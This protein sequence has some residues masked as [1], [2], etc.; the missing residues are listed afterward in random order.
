MTSHKINNRQIRVFISSTFK[1]MHSERDYLINH[2]FPQIRLYCQR[3]NIIFTEIDL[4]WG[5]TESQAENGQVIKLCLD[6]IDR[7]HPFFIGLVGDRYGY[8][9]S[10]EEVE[11]N[12][13]L[14]EQHDWIFD[15]IDQQQSITEIEIQYGVLRSNDPI[16]GRFFLRE[17]AKNVGNDIRTSECNKLEHLKDAIRHQNK[18]PYSIYTTI[19]SLGEMV[20]DALV[21]VIDTLYPDPVLSVYDQQ[22]LKQESRRT[23][24]LEHYISVDEDLDRLESFAKH[25][26]DQRMILIGESGCGKTSLLCDWE[27]KS[28]IPIISYYIGASSITETPAQILKYLIHAISHRFGIKYYDTYRTSFEVDEQ[29]NLTNEFLSICQKTTEPWILIIDGIDQLS[30]EEDLSMSWIPN[31]PSH[32]KTVYSARINSIACKYAQQRNITFYEISNL[33]VYKRAR[34]AEKYYATYGKTLPSD[35]LSQLATTCS[36]KTPYTYI[37]ILNEIRKYGSHET[38]GEYIKRY[39]DEENEEI[40]YTFI[41]QNLASFENKQEEVAFHTICAYLSIS[42]FGLTERE[43]MDIC[44][45]TPMI[46]AAIHSRLYFHI[47]HCDGLI[48]FKNSTFAEVIKR[49][50][51]YDNTYITTCRE[52]IIKYFIRIKNSPFYISQREHEEFAWQLLQTGNYKKLNS[53]A[54]QLN[55]F[56]TWLKRDTLTYSV[57]SLFWDALEDHGYPISGLFCEEDTAV[58]TEQLIMLGNVCHF[59]FKTGRINDFNHLCD[60]LGKLYKNLMDKDIDAAIIEYVQLLQLRYNHV[61]SLGD[62]D[63]GERYMLEVLDLLLRRNH[64]VEEPYNQMIF[65]YYIVSTYNNLGNCFAAINLYD[66]AIYYYEKALNLTIEHDVNHRIE[67]SLIIAKSNLAFTHFTQGYKDRSWKEILEVYN[68]AKNISNLSTV[69]SIALKMGKM[70]K[71]GNTAISYIRQAIDIYKSMPNKKKVLATAYIQM[72]ER[73]FYIKDF[74]NTERYYERAIDLLKSQEDNKNLY[75]KTLF[76]IANFYMIT[77]QSNKVD[78]YVKKAIDKL[79][80]IFLPTAYESWILANLLRIYA[81]AKLMQPDMNSSLLFFRQSLAAFNALQNQLDQPNPSITTYITDIEGQINRL[82]LTINS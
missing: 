22:V 38:L 72:A 54:T 68:Q 12:R 77:Q 76:D 73:C 3:R 70:A 23:E 35:L 44:S 79:E 40:L 18:I 39:C 62:Y 45:I 30:S 27:R 15:A 71:E 53:L 13:E 41:I 29:Y 11:K 10:R 25:L 17:N 46:W 78:K 52:A 61:F 69:A 74:N 36:A 9:P 81:Y 66:Q 37:A 42:H 16:Y 75:Y 56:D 49:L 67:E 60:R 6:E 7:S 26:S 8:V 58:T 50:Y 20:Y 64:A 24:C 57:C 43:I 80:K 32:I 31:L 65:T 21:S 55:V 59:C 5:I 19:E 48:R 4:R 51:A 63:A 33:N 47:E 34:I 28:G 14:L 1:D 82:T 2:T